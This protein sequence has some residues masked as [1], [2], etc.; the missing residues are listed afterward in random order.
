MEYQKIRCPCCSNNILIRLDDTGKVSGVFFD[1]EKLSSDE[2]FT[3]YG[4]CLGV[5]GGE[6]DES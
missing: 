2:A 4:I 5:K 3:Q 6:T 1:G